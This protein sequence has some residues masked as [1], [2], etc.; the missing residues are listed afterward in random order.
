MENNIYIGIDISFTK[1]GIVI[2]SEKENIISMNLLVESDDTKTKPIRNVNIFR[3]GYSKIILPKDRYS[4]SEL[5]YTKR[6]IA[7]ANKIMSIICSYV[8]KDANVFVNIEG[9]QMSDLNSSRLFQLIMLQSMVRQKLSS[10]PNLKMKITNISTLKKEFTGNGHAE[11]T[12]MLKAFFDNWDAKKLLPNS[13]YTDLELN[14][15]CDAF[16]LVVNF[17]AS[18]RGLYTQPKPKPKK[19]RKKVTKNVLTIEKMFG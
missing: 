8:V 3:Y 18:I 13:K 2:F 14:D 10:I 4:E 6:S 7:C 5:N 1:T 19:K 9:W 17:I 16:A 12:D 15:I 11:K